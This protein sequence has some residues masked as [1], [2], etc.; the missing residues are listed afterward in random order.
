[1][2]Q[3][4]R[5]DPGGV[6][7][8]IDEAIKTIDIMLPG[9]RFDND[10]K[11]AWINEIEGKIFEELHMG[12]RLLRETDTPI[13]SIKPGQII[14]WWRKGNHQWTNEILESQEPAED[15]EDHGYAVEINPLNMCPPPPKKVINELKPY[16]YESNKQTMLIAPDRF[17][18]VYTHYV[19]AKMHAADS[20]IEEYNNEVILYTAAIQDFYGWYLR[21]YGQE[22]PSG[23]IF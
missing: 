7:M 17:S 2:G 3:V 4:G 5:M 19:I 16:R 15:E 13:D 21:A 10:M 20:E 8:T 12:D 9:N 23:Y 22:G 14:F 18:D 1:M 6:D 11:T